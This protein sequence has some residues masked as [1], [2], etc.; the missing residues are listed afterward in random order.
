[1]E[2]MNLPIV[3]LRITHCAVVLSGHKEG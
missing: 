2:T 1:M 3:A